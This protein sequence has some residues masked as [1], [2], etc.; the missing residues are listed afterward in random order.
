MSLDINAILQALAS[1]P[2]LAAQLSA[3]LQADQGVTAPRTLKPT[4]LPPIASM[5]AAQATAWYNGANGKGVRHKLTLECWSVP[6]ST[7][8]VRRPTHTVH[9]GM[10]EY[11]TFRDQIKGLASREII[12]QEYHDDVCDVLDVYKDMT[13]SALIMCGLLRSKSKGTHY[14]PKQWAFA[15]HDRKSL[16]IEA[17]AL[18]VSGEKI[19]FPNFVTTNCK[20]APLKAPATSQSRVDLSGFSSGFVHPWITSEIS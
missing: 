11:W 10:S 2:E 17:A 14:F 13:D 1:N 19:K 20:G 5:T 9:A 3:M 12:T 15:V 18:F 8:N 4:G 7:I 6:A 16:A